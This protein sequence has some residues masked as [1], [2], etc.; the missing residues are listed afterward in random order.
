[1]MR[2]LFLMP[3]LDCS[4]KVG[5]VPAGRG[6]IEPIRLHWIQFRKNVQTEHELRGDHFQVLEMPLWQFE[7]DEIQSLC[8]KD[9]YDIV[10]IPHKEDRNFLIT[11]RTRPLYY[12]QTQ[13]PWIF[14]VDSKG[15]G[16]GAS[17]YP[18]NSVPTAN[19]A[20]YD[21]LRTISVTGK[22]KFGQPVRGTNL[23]MLPTDPFIF[24]PCQLPHDET[25]KF[26][27][28][29]SVEDALS[30]TC[31]AAIELNV[32]LV[33]KGHPVNPGSMSPLQDIVGKLRSDR[34]IQWINDI[35]IQDV[36]EKAA[37]TVTVNS[38]VGFESLL[39]R[40]PVMTFGDAEYDA[41][42]FKVTPETLEQA[43]NSELKF[44][45]ESVYGF[46]EHWTN[47]TYDTTNQGSF[48]KLRA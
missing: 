45:P 33:I 11:G 41:V 44:R 46:F 8:D 25:I 13:F 16:S 6:P 30:I 5:Y 40:T 36:L 9:Q 17:A 4:F 27:S 26:H 19:S 15:W 22:S 10:Y 31:N 28:S 47:W 14:S 2:V 48:R 34:R 43:L 23:N 29:V 3:R 20:A 21:K 42:A 35:N 39:M 18:F 12:M 32:P 1:M 38:G 7:V 37:V 24:F